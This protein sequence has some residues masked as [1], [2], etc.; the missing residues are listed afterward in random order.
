MRGN[1]GYKNISLYGDYL[2][3]GRVVK[4]TYVTNVTNITNVVAHP[5]FNGG[6]H[7][8]KHCHRKHERTEKPPKLARFCASG[9]L[10]DQDVAMRMSGGEIFSGI[11]AVGGY[12]ARGVVKHAGNIIRN[13]RDLG[14]G[15]CQIVGNAFGIVKDVCELIG[16]IL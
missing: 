8:F 7:H 9:G 2:P 1:T 13:N 11:A 4:N 6:K 12:A 15:A 3:H 5:H 16:M 10:L 14:D